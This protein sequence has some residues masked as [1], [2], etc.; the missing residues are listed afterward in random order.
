MGEKRGDRNDALRLSPLARLRTAPRTSAPRATLQLG[1][2]GE[3]RSLI[4][5]LLE[6]VAMDTYVA[7]VAVRGTHGLFSS[8]N[9]HRRPTDGYLY[10]F[11]FSSR[12]S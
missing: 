5:R 2:H 4:W 1:R 3:T 12:P 6:R 9:Y 8:H 11:F 10:S 7:I